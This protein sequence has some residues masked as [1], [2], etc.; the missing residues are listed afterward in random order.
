MQAKARSTS[1]P[2]RSQL[3]ALA[4]MSGNDVELYAFW[5]AAKA[6]D[7]HSFS[8]DSVIQLPPEVFI[9]GIKRNKSSLFVR[10]DYV[11]LEKEILRL[12][13]LSSSHSVGVIGNP[14]IGKTY[15]SYYLLMKAASEGRSVV[16]ESS[17]LE[18][19][20]PQWYVFHGDIC[21]KVHVN[22]PYAYTLLKDANTLYLVDAR[23]PKLVDAPTVLITSPRKDIYDHFCRKRSCNGQPLYMPVWSW[24]ELLKL[25]KSCFP[26]A[27]LAEM[28]AVY[29]RWGG[30][31]R[32]VLSYRK[33]NVER[34]GTVNDPLSAAIGQ[35]QVDTIVATMSVGT[36]GPAVSHRLFHAVSS[37]PTYQLMGYE[38]ASDYVNE[39][40]MKHWADVNEQKLMEFAVFSH[41]D[42]I[43]GA[44][45]GTP[46]NT[47]L[48]NNCKQGAPSVSENLTHRM[49]LPIWSSR[50][51][52]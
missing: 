20:Q 10:A 36:E 22:H 24:E 44:L 30:I 3:S 46:S 35:I 40:L 45:R 33:E 52:P 19:D 18:G 14:G 31:A 5:Q 25:H 7:A 29:L 51:L 38:I 16:Y 48:T 28:N 47:L 13:S 50:I 12:F 11:G 8:A 37:P 21:C 39:E 17:E 23:V 43:L 1:F 27:D 15:F 34:R 26:A 6:L 9:L 49:L 42:P 41:S 32:E 2:V 4:H